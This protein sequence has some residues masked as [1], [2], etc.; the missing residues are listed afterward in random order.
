MEAILEGSLKLI[1][2]KGF[3]GFGMRAL[4]KEIGMSQGN[5]Y[6]YISSQRELWIACRIKIMHVFK[7]KIEKIA[8]STNGDPIKR[9]I[10]IGKF[11]LDYA[12][13]DLNRWKLI[14]GAVNPPEAPLDEKGNP[15]IGDYEKNYSSMRVLDVIFQI[16]KEASYQKIITVENYKLLGFYLYSIVIGL[17]FTEPD[18]LLEEQ[19]RES[20]VHDDLFFDKDEL[21]MLAFTQMERL[22]RE[23]YGELG[24]N[25]NLD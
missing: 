1:Y 12:A 25:E 16:L 15:I 18:L 3:N 10:N 19:I 23:G 11:V 2:E 22:L 6:N 24:K 8:F 21:R 20:V 7:T 5:L 9:L 4:A 17:T 13:E 14:T